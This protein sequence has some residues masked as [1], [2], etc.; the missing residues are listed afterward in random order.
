[1]SAPTKTAVAGKFQT[2][3]DDFVQ[4][5]SDR[6]SVIGW[7]DSDAIQ[8]A[9]DFVTLGGVNGGISL[10][11]LKQMFDTFVLSGLPNHIDE[12]TF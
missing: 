11:D 6:G 1:M 12:G 10:I 7:T 3:G 4:Y 8:Y 2:R 5:V 9:E